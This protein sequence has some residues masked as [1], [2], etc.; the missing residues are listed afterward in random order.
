[1][2]LALLLLLSTSAALA[3][4]PGETPTAPAPAP[5]PAPVPPGLTALEPSSIPEQCRELAKIADSHSPA[6]AWSARISLASC[7]VDDKLRSL[8]LCDCEQSVRE[9]EA[10]SQLSLMLLDEVFVAAD[11]ATQILARNAKGEL[12][13]SLATRM[14]ATVPPPVNNTQEAI[15]L[16]DTRMQ[17]LQPMVD[18]WIIQARSAFAEVDKIAR[19]N[20]QLAKNSAVVAAVRSAR[21]Q[22]SQV[23]KR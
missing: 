12:L 10:A 4:P 16:R 5:A 22:I 21:A 8:A 14:L 6:R 7:L 9:V 19:A 13:S 1:M 18:P 3:A 20:P 15:A 17:L 2:R 23:A 11:P